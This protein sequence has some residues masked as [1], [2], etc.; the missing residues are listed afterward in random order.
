MHV[1]F[2]LN[3]Q[4]ENCTNQ[5]N[6]THPSCLS[7]TPLN[8]H[9]CNNTFFPPF[10]IISLFELMYFYSDMKETWQLE[11]KT[12]RSS[13]GAGERVQNNPRPE[14]GEV[15]SIGIHSSP[16]MLDL[17]GFLAAADCSSDTLTSPPHT[18][19]KRATV[20]I[21]LNCVRDGRGN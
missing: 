18:V 14:R 15:G 10:F 2:F 5:S 19:S 1:Q 4:T 16:S 6:M 11:E 17:V 21:G 3:M 13:E 9:S 20:L 8:L 7:V 12:K